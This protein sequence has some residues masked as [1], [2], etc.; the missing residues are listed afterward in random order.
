MVWYFIGVYIIN[1]TLHGRLEIRNFSS[2]VEITFHEWAQRYFSKLEAKFRIPARPCNILSIS[3]TGLHWGVL[4]AFCFLQL[5]TRS[6]L[7]LC[8]RYPA[9][10]PVHLLAMTRVASRVIQWVINNL[11]TCLLLLQFQSQS[12]SQE[13]AL[14][15][16]RTLAHLLDAPQPAATRY[17]TPHLINTVNVTTPQ[18]QWREQRNT[19]SSTN[20]T[21]RIEKKVNRNE[22]GRRRRKRTL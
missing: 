13:L 4:T 17:T 18:G 8:A 15:P 12:Q 9:H 3:V 20:F 10:Q 16:A 5:V 6:L 7:H 1:R 22:Q 14:T 21:G 19:T 2:R 11:I